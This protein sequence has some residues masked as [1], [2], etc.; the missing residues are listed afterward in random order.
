MGDSRHA[1][2][3]RLGRLH[4]WRE[5]GSL[6][7]DGLRTSAQAAILTAGVA[8]GADFTGTAWA[9]G[10]GLGLFLALEGAK[11]LAGWLDARFDV[12]RAHTQAVA[13]QNPI[14]MR[15]LHALERL[16]PATD[17]RGGCV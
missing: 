9:V 16:S 15:Q 14:I 11:V 7:V 1:L 6:Y 4:S 10:L 13:E 17:V 12:W 5:R 3:P 2:G 8:K